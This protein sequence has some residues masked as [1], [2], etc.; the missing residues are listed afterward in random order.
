MNNN[1][2]VKDHFD[3]LSTSYQSNYSMELSGRTYDFCKRLSLV[4]KI[5]SNKSGKLIDC[6]C[7]T[8]E[9][10]FELL[11][12]GN[13]KRAVICDISGRMLDIAKQKQTQLKSDIDIEFV[14][15]D[16]FDYNP[17]PR[18]K[19]DLILCLGLLAHIDSFEKLL[20]QM[21]LMLSSNGEIILQSSLTDNWSVRVTRFISENIYKKRFGYNV[22]YYSHSTIESKVK[23][24]GLKIVDVRRYK[25]GFPFGDRVSRRI[26]YYLEKFMSF[27]SN[28]Y[29][30]EAIY[31][32]KKI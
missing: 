15:T 23:S 4:S 25:F 17:N 19:F 30:A 2:Y 6:A 18:E 27:I 28:K 8:G 21:N 7:G 14:Q 22:T 5:V 20:N 29:G 32:I 3:T 13:F 24:A 1:K 26:N 31:V 9:I 11:K 16:I 12:G 10:T